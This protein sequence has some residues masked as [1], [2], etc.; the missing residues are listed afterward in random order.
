V[1]IL[2]LP[3]PVVERLTAAGIGADLLSGRQVRATNGR[4]ELRVTA[5][6]ALEFE[7]YATTWDDFY[8]VAGGPPYGWREQFANGS[9]KKALREKDDVRLLVNHDGVPL[10]RTR[11]KTLTLEADDLGLR[12]SALLDP[13]NPTVAEIR[14]A[15]GRGDMD[16]MSLAFMVVKQEWNGDYTERT[17]KEAR[18]FDVSVVTYPA[19]PNTAAALRRETPGGLELIEF[20]PEVQDRTGMPLSLAS[21]IAEASRLRRA[22]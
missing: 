6:G 21:A 5:E 18:L 7:G 14:S 15:M 20:D 4:I 9:L 22:G 16:E 8:D 19:N 2:D 11:S 12:T 13:G 1:T 10:A 3:Q 17:I